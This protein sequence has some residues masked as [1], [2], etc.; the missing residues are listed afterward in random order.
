MIIYVSLIIVILLYF[1]ILC[2]IAFNFYRIM[3]KQCKVTLIPLTIFYVCSTTIVITR[4][5]NN[6]AFFNYFYSDLTEDS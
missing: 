4:I 2:F 1:V 6:A 5:I 3:I